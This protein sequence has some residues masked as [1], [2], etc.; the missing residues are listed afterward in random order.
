MNWDSVL[1]HTL[2]LVRSAATST[3]FNDALDTMLNAAGPMALSTSYF[4]DTLPT[5]LKRNRDWNW[6]D[7]SSFRS[8][9]QVILDTIRNNFRP[10]TECWVENNTYTTSNTSYLIFPYDSLELNVNTSTAYPDADHRQLMMFK[11]WNIVR[12]LYP[13]N[14]ILD[15]PC[16]TT[17]YHYVIPMDTVSNPASLDLV[18]LQV[19]TA[20]ND[21]HT[22]AYTGSYIYPLPP[23]FYHPRILLRY[24]DSQYVVVKSQ[25][26]GIYPGDAIIS[27]NGKTTSQWEDSLKHYYSAGN[28][29]VFR[30]DMYT[31]VLGMVNAGT[32]TLV[33]EDSMGVN[34]TV[35]PTCIW[36]GTDA[37][38]FGSSYYPA[39]SIGT[40]SW[41]TMPCDIGYVNM[42]NLQPSDVNAMYNDLHSKNTIIFD[43]RNYPKGTVYDITNLMYPSQ[44]TFAKLTIPDLTYPG[45]YYWQYETS[46]VFGNPTPYTGKIIIL[47]NEQ[48]QSQA[49]FT[50][51][52]LKAMPNVV[53]VGS[54]TAGADGD[55]TY[56]H[57]SRDLET[58]F[59]TLG[60]FYPNGDS[61]QRIGIVPDSVVYPTKAGI[62]HGDDEVLDKALEIACSAASIPK[63]SNNITSIKAFPNPANDIVTIDANN[64][65]AQE[66]SI[67]ITDI[68]GR[69]LLQKTVENT[70]QKISTT[71][72]VRALSSGLYFLNVKAGEQ[73]W[74]TK[75]IKN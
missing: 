51:M 36:P 75:F 61:T 41:T 27:V 18:Y 68:T 73:L 12:Y 62:R 45:A 23:G 56:W 4:P 58:G 39:D 74:V 59:S 35:T 53:V 55:V 21:A 72:N 50:C 25:E 31:F 16:D 20:L 37:A 57:L 46:G 69:V 40:I 60:V 26:T 7:S 67:N 33:I 2:P 9:V 65:N 44:I 49:E 32:T 28:L 22:E 48:T 54:Q 15:M 10:H 66:A 5:E 30:R 11:F 8:D 1:L 34:H 38:F 6:I 71:F 63:I 3:Q 13:N 47:I 17:L 43:L 70:N 42:G 64:L 24:A 29:S 52:A 19:G 14:Y